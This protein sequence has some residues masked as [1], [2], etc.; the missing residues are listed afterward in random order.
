V[1]EPAP[2]VPF[3]LEATEDTA[4]KES[5][6]EVAVVETEAS[7]QVEE[8]SAFTVAAPLETEAPAPVE[9]EAETISEPEPA[10]EPEPVNVT[11][12]MWGSVAA[13]ATPAAEP[14]PEPTEVAEP[15]AE[16]PEFMVASVEPTETELKAETVE[17]TVES[18]STED[19]TAP[20]ATETTPAEPQSY[21]LSG[22]GAG[23]GLGALSA[24]TE[25]SGV[26][27]PSGAGGAEEE[28]V[29]IDATEDVLPE[30]D[31]KPAL[32]AGV[33][34]IASS[35]NVEN[36]SDP[37]AAPQDAEGESDILKPRTRFNPWD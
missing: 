4:D 19:S 15:V 30:I 36:A 27:G 9:P 34:P 13:A 24:K 21:S 5:V 22:I 16:T 18:V 35:I 6:D 11:S 32:P 10:P 3:G 29:V 12:T 8:V 14:A 20:V 31:G 2:Y 28:K 26:P 17:E 33:A 25:A 1:S 7:D 37:A 23:F